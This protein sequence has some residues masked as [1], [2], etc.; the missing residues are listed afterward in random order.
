ME[1]P[2][3]SSEVA[4]KA[5]HITGLDSIRFFCALWVVFFHGNLPPLLEGMEH[6]PKLVWLRLIRGIYGSAFNGPAA[7]IVFF[8]VSGFCIH[9]PQRNS[10]KVR[11][12]EFY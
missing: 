11:V 3:K 4:S 10:L 5:S 1:Q 6:A 8:L 9:F 2:A 7:V 12:G